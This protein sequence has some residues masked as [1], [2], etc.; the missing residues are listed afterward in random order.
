MDKIKIGNRT[1]F[2]GA[3][4]PKTLNVLREKIKI[5][6][7]PDVDSEGKTDVGDAILFILTAVF[8]GD[9]EKALEIGQELAKTEIKNVTIEQLIEAIELI[10]GSCDS[11]LN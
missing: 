5:L 9:E 1:F 4:T 6:K 3:I 8:D 7:I 10:R 11:H 2:L